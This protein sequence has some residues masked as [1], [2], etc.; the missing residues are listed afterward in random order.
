[1]TAIVLV[2]IVGYFLFAAS[3]NAWLGLNLVATGLAAW[4]W[5]GFAQ[6]TEKIKKVVFSVLVT[7]I[8]WVSLY[9]LSTDAL[10]ILTLLIA[11]LMFWSV[12]RYQNTQGAA[13]FK[14]Q[15]V[16]LT[17]GL[18]TLLMF[19]Q[20]IVHFK[21]VFSPLTLLLS[22]A[23]VWAIDT[24]AYFSGRKFGKK[25]L[26]VHVSPGK[27]WEGVWGGG[28][29]SFVL[30]FSGLNWLAPELKIS[31]GL[32]AFL[33]ALIAAYS[34]MGDLFESL[35]KRQAEIKDSGSV[36]PGHGGILDRID[37]LIIAVPMFYFLWVWVSF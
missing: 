29:L 16:I 30:A 33:M 5:A 10:L 25:K 32:M 34:V 11:I 15:P 36:F 14:S 23:V 27:S 28:V 1:M 9:L 26:A 18:L 20:G 17:L 24:G 13:V 21:E 3:M 4:E 7:L 2:A 8:S 22:L 35:L 37:S 31:Y 12:M 6:I 19:F